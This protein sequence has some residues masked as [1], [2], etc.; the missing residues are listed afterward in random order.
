M[1]FDSRDVERKV[2]AILR[3]L[4]NSQG[5]LGARLIAQ[6][7]REYGIALSERAVRYHLKLTDERGLTDLVGKIDGRAITQKGLAEI[8]DGLVKDKVGYAISRIEQLAF[9]TNFD[10]LNRRGLVPINVSFFSTPQFAS[11]VRA[12]RPVFAA[13]LC[14]SQLVAVAESGERIGD[15]VVPENKTALATVCSIV[16]NG[17]LL[18]S[19]IPMDSRFGGILQV[20][21]RK[22][23]R[24]VE[25][26]H[27]NGCSLDP[28]EIFM[29]A[30]MTS[31]VAAAQNGSGEILAN[32]REIPA[33]CSP[34]A[35]RVFGDLKAA[36]LGQVMSLGTPSD[37]VCEVPVEQNKIG[38]VLLGGLNPVAAA[39]EEEFEVDNQSMA[40]VIDYGRLQPFEALAES[41]H[42]RIA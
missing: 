5:P 25:I 31:V 35:E 28:S 26:I 38:V 20:K 23:K 11:A 12:M 27:Y 10:C 37:P 40:T 19:G 18:K 36:G 24:F 3:V 32:F 16:V 13:E 33:I 15:A 4:S 41:S 7:L 29:K 9:R 22:P 42:S 8:R 2:L 17:T 30:R 21:D 34:I 1:S 14:A 6:A 39:M